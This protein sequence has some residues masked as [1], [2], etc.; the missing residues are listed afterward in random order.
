MYDCKKLLFLFICI[1]IRVKYILFAVSDTNDSLITR[2]Y[3]LL[4]FSR[5]KSKLVHLMIISSVLL[6]VNIFVPHIPIDLSEQLG[7]EFLDK[8]WCWSC[9]ILSS[10]MRVSNI[11]YSFIHVFRA[12]GITHHFE[13]YVFVKLPFH[14]CKV[15][16]NLNY[17]SYL[18]LLEILIDW[19]PCF[20]YV[21]SVMFQPCN[22]G[23]L[24]RIWRY[25]HLYV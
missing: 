19:L 16:K 12:P 15:K 4:L 21:V 5:K 2:M 20:F 10:F 3:I 7:L 9:R 8:V 6:L 23:L 24:E 11:S 18:F 25:N 14:F 1:H 13:L 22:G 17:Y